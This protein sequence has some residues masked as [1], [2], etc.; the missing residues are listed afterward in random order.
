VGLNLDGL[1]AESWQIYKEAFHTKDSPVVRRS[2]PILFFGDSDGY[3]RSAIRVITVGLNPSRE[4]FPQSNR[5]ARF[6]GAQG[7]YPSILG[8]AGY[9]EYK[10]ALDAYFR[11]NPYWSWFAAWEPLLEGLD[12]SFHGGKSNTAL[13][14]DMCSPLA[15]DPTWRKLPRNV[16]AELIRRGRPLWNRLVQVLAPDL[17]LFSVAQRHV[18]DVAPQPVER[19]SVVYTIDRDNPFHVRGTPVDNLVP[20]RRTELVFGRCAN[21]AFGTVSYADKRL[22]GR[23]LGRMLDAG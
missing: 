5:F 22:I 23:H 8:T 14:T 11:T 20:G 18:D 2:M 3:F 9:P 21:R 1:I 6:P 19:W 10:A 16:Q 13:H 17:I 4:E 7:L 12:G 15:T